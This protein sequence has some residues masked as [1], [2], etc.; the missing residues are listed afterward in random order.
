MIL[1]RLRSL[2]RGLIHR[3]RLEEEMADEFRHHLQ[4]RTEDLV[5][6]GLS[7]DEAARR[8]RLEF[9]HMDG[10][11]ADARTSR[12]LGPFDAIRFSA[13]DVKLGLRMLVK[14]P[15]LSVV[16][17]TGMAVAIAI[18]VGAFS[19]IASLTETG[20]PLPEGDRVVALRNAN[21][22]EP[23]RNRASLRDF[24]AWRELK[25][26]Q[27]VSA[28]TLIS[29]TLVVPGASVDLVRVARMTASGFKIAGVRP[30]LGRTLLEEDELSDARVAVIGFDE[31]QRRF[32]GDRGI[33][34]RRLA[35]GTD[36]YTIVGVMP[37]GF[38]FPVNDH[39]WIPLVFAPH[40]RERSDAVS[41]TIFGRLAE[42][43]SIEGAQAELS[44]IGARMARAYPETHGKLRPRVVSYTRAF[45]DIDT[46][47]IVRTMQLFWLFI[48]LLLVVVAV[49]VAILVYARTATRVGEIAVRTAL[50]ASR[51][52]VVTQLF[53]EALVLSV[54]AAVV[55][56]TIAGVA[57]AKLQA[58]AGQS[59]FERRLGKLPFWLDVGLSPGVITYALVLA[60]V[61]AAIVGVLPALKATGRR[62]HTSLKQLSGNGARMQLG[63]AWT[64]LIIAQVAV[65]VAVLPFAVAFTQE[66]IADATQDPGY[67]ADEFLE[68]SLTIDRADEPHNASDA[69]Q[70]A[71]ETRFRARAAELIRRVES[72][73]EVAGVSIAIRGDERLEVEG[74]ASPG[75]DR[76][77]IA[78]GTK[79][80]ERI[81][82]DFFALYGMP[83]LSGRAFIAADMRVGATGVIVNQ[84][85]AENRFGNVAVLGRRL[86][87]VRESDLG[88]GE[89]GPWLEI[90]GV[91]RDFEAHANEPLDRIYLPA[92][93]ARL[94]APVTIAIRVRVNP[95]TS[96]VPRL[97]AMAAA[98]DPLLQL[99]Q[100]VTAAERHRQSQRFLRYI[101]IGTLAVMLSVLLLSAAGIYAMMS[102]TVASRRR[103]IGIRSALGADPRRLLSSIFARA[104]AQLGAGILLGMI[105]TIAVDRVTARGPVHDG[106]PMVLPF[107]AAMM[108]VVGLLAAIRPARRGLA[109]QPTDA[110]REE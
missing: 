90:V 20:L 7:P 45:F 54:T 107:V 66:V 3:D 81:D 47:E 104:T 25:S 35:F 42:Q 61:G 52:R 94:P 63:R 77:P 29:K 109:V 88:K 33:T 14:Y 101:G 46:P 59:Q 71:I 64:A 76:R 108:A 15:G 62:M 27:D 9:G 97:R 23:G 58:L 86:R 98:V 36:V 2:W 50:G 32:A 19:V 100:L 85:F 78:V 34:G 5:R 12:G 6:R 92:D 30:L 83:M 56:L 60:V 55:G 84:V 82:E 91:V 51:A 21:I 48:S 68:A 67:P 74:I 8:A 49:N 69:G 17:V 72:D 95:A 99:D 41:L 39:F 1:S 16:A 105:G 24:I 44:A 22:T 18:G 28:F 87:L 4:L 10:H 31:W 75:E 79:R 103:E 40:E 57:L 13:L 80:V 93:L 106:N 110:L 89:A 102:F 65:A 70:Q 38:R 11:K 96:F 73:P 26:V 53:A 37:D 43:V